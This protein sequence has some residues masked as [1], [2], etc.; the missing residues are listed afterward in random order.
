M[1]DEK[2]GT[3]FGQSRFGRPDLTNFG[4]IQH[5]QVKNKQHRTTLTSW[6]NH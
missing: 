1:R 6:P 2:E 5:K 3:D 4:Q